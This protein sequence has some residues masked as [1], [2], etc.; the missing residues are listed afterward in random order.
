MSAVVELGEQRVLRALFAY[1]ARGW[2][3]FP[4]HSVSEGVCSCPE[5]A[6]CGNPGKHPRIATGFRAATI[7][8][9]RVAS[10]HKQWPGCNW[11]LAC[12]ASGLAVVDVDP[13]NNGDESLAALET[14]H[15][16]L[17]TTT[18]AL[19]G[20]GGQHYLYS[21]EGVDVPCRTIALG[22]D[23][24]A[25]GGYI[26]LAPSSHASGRDYAWDAGAH[27]NDISPQP[28]P[29]WVRALAGE[30]KTAEKFEP[31]GAVT[32]GFLGACF[33]ELGWLGRALGPDKNCA[34][35]PNESNHTGGSRW[36]SS[37]V[38]FAPR[39]GATLGHFHCSH[40]HCSTLTA[41]DI[42]AEIPREVQD[43][44]RIRSFGSDYNQDA[45]SETVAV[46]SSMAEQQ[47]DWIRAVRYT[48]DGKLTRDAGNA[49]LMIAN[50]PEWAGCLEFDAFADR[51]RWSRPVPTM[52]GIVAPALGEELADHH[53]TYVHHWLA[54]HCGVGFAKQAV[55]DALESAAHANP[56]HPV[57]DYLAG[58]VWDGTP[59]I[60]RW[61]VDYL[62][63][64]T[65]PHVLAVSRWWLVSAVARVQDPGC[66][67]DHIIVLE[68]GQGAGKST[69]AKILGGEWYLGSLPDIAQKDAA[70]LLQGHWI[71][72]IGELD[73]FKGSAATRVKNWVTTRVDAYR[74]AYG[75][76]TVRR[77][78]QCVFV[79]TTNE[80]HYLADPSGARRFWPVAVHNLRRSELERDRDQLWA[81]AAHAWHSGET[82][83]PTEEHREGL[84]A[85][86]E[87][88]HD[89]DSW[90]HRVAAWVADRPPFTIGELMAGCLDLEPGKWDRRV[91]TRVGVCLTRLGY[92]SKQCRENGSHV[93]RYHTV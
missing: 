38:L 88:R 3:I 2:H 11:G 55:Q 77:P 1:T 34:Q 66:Q 63:A 50:L 4:L 30:K 7:D 53:I 35:C 29:A 13:R 42:L 85:A 6:T 76:Y 72:E 93:R 84:L 41:K 10:W 71:V 31:S 49:A 40:S 83:H 82:W 21:V 46:A 67:A 68:G 20:G 54:R 14:K 23:L 80:T 43:A 58:L 69:A 22:V 89:E 75:R 52:S 44:V 62:G 86:Q 8:R 17:T 24:K 60:D 74:P 25:S 78:R 81:E 39:R 65:A 18:T 33:A 48:A 12:G 9:D 91:Q 5:G 56:R 32:D 51:V 19:T 90:E 57:R 70:A 16:K 61:L 15:G 36:D 64:R 87:E 47:G 37:T 27:P 73:A 26:V 45:A 79:G 92:I 28:L 59:R